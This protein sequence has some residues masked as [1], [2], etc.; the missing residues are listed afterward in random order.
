MPEMKTLN[1]YE[2]VDAKARKD[3]E[4]LQEAVEN[5][6]ISKLDLSD[7]AK[8]AELPTK[9]SQLTNDNRFITLAE[10]PK[11]DLSNYALKASV[12]TKVSQLQNDSNF[13]TRD[14]VQNPDLS[15]YAKKDEIPD[16]SDF[17]TSIPSEYITESEL[18]AKGYL[19]EHQSL[20][21]YATKSYVGAKIDSIKCDSFYLDF[22]DAVLNTPK[23]ATEKMIEFAEF[24]SS[25][26][27]ADMDA[28]AY[29]KDTHDTS[30]YYPALISPS[31]S[32]GLFRVY[33]TKA[34]VNLNNIAARTNNK[35]DTIMLYSMADGSW[36]YNLLGAGE[37][38]F[39]SENY[40]NDALANI[41]LDGYAT[42]TFVT[43]KIA[44]AQLNVEDDPIDLS[45]YATKDDIKNFITEVPAEY[46][47]ETE[48]NRKGYLTEHQS[49]EG[50][51]SEKYVR[52]AIAGIDIPDPDLS[53]Y[54]K[55]TDIPD[56]STKADKEHTHSQYI[57]SIPSEYVT[58][59]ELNAKGYLTQHQSLAGLATTQE[60]LAN[61]TEIAAVEA[62]VD[63]LES[64]AS[65]YLT[66][67]PSEYITETELNNKN[68]VTSSA[69]SAAYYSKTDGQDNEAAIAEIK[70]T[71]AT[72]AYVNSAVANAGSGGGGGSGKTT[73]NIENVEYLTS[74]QVTKLSALWDSIN[75][76]NLSALSNYEITV[77]GDAEVQITGMSTND[78]ASNKWFNVCGVS[79]ANRVNKGAIYVGRIYVKTSS[80]VWLKRYEIVTEDTFNDYLSEDSTIQSI[81]A[82]ISAIKV[83]LGL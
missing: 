14:E 76:G 55:K 37:F 15:E 40:V 74:E 19:T 71:Y 22:S 72:K 33:L 28:C 51:A 4:G 53:D 83:K 7:Y 20:A 69:A 62:R 2:V 60:V 24:I 23:P 36:K 10:V 80:Q 30:I 56:I 3:I 39:A 79:A 63:T 75:A 8:K 25:D 35:W 59:S 73:I 57:T 12:P 54:A 21:N 29:I 58:E 81:Q 65:K 5:I 42:E 38:T 34:S 68:Y 18:N 67:I 32:N 66:S 9:T 52:D 43:N 78:D 17:I 50:L 45:G 11:T 47:T 44:E 6:D 49:L 13:I 64:E 1:G 70:N 61:S 27:G 31:W 77:S 48:L 82:D 46:I 41:S 26:S 16:V